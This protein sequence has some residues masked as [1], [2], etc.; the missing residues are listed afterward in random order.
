[1]AARIMIVEDERIVAFNLQQ[2]LLKLGYEVPMVVASGEQALRGIDN[3]QPDVVL[4]DIHIE[5]DID[6]IET[7][8]RIGVNSHTPIIYLTAHSEEMTLDRAR[9]TKP[10]GYLI[11]P[12]S[13]RE[14]HATIQMTLERWR[15]EQAL[16]A[17]KLE[18]E[19]INTSLEEKIDERTR[20]LALAKHEAEVANREKSLFLAN[21]SHEIRTPL[22]AVL[23]LCYL[24]QKTDLTAQQCDYVKKADASA[25]FLLGILND[26]L[27]FSK[28]EAGKLELERVDFSLDDLLKNVGTIISVQ[29][30]ARGLD[31][32]VNLNNA[33]ELALCGDPLRLQQILMNLGSNAVKFTEHGTV[34][35]SVRVMAQSEQ[36]TRLYFS[37]RD[38]GPGLSHEQV[39]SLFA[40]FHQADLS[41]TRRYGGSGLGL[42]ICKR[43]V[44]LMGGDIGVDSML[45]QGSNFYFELTLPRGQLKKALGHS[46]HLEDAKLAL[47][48]KRILLVE[49][50]QINREVAC[51]ILQHE[52]IV[53]DV[54]GNGA[55]AI[56]KILHAGGKFYDAVLMDLQMPELDGVAATQQIRAL[57]DTA[58][59]PILAMTADAVAEVRA[60]CLQIGMND[61][62]LKP[63]R[64]P[65]LFATLDRWLNKAQPDTA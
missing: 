35:I 59:L 55:A 34:T 48:G 33:M 18:I 64:I 49:D 3:E 26:I 62:V 51:A 10:Y 42:A 12:F 57:H 53:V 27:D 58:Q 37:V 15:V 30:Q 4:M 63:I 19:R 20:Q 44:Q 50:N 22:N 41:T 8:K 36:A 56:E 38:T 9:A 11:K 39:E 14:L 25:Q 5:G 24:L 60:R 13:E 61:F 16:R 65:Q 17:A 32:Q 45:G 43:L 40:A 28:V 21:M 1:M 47:R 7:A 31:L 46:R 52:G 6:G 23:G 54:A 2:R 29:A